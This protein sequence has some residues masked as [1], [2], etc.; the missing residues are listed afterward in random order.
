MELKGNI[1]VC[2]RDRNRWVVRGEMRRAKKLLKERRAPRRRGR[3]LG[4]A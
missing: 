1:A 3:N 2:C 4:P